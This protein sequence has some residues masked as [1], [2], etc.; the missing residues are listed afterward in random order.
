MLARASGPVVAH[1]ARFRR[2]ALQAV[3]RVSA[4]AV[5]R[6]RPGGRTVRVPVALGRGHVVAGPMGAAAAAAARVG[7]AP[8]GRVAGVTVG[9]RALR[10]VQYRPAKRVQAT[11]IFHAT[12]VDATSVDARLFVCTLT[13]VDAFDRW[14]DAS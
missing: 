6:A 7:R 13:V 11:S 1:R 9:A 14:R 8:G 2:R 12:R 3:A 10:P 4:R 5:R